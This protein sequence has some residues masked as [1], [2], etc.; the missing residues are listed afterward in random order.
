MAQEH[1]VFEGGDDG[2][3]IMAPMLVDKLQVSYTPRPRCSDSQTLFSA[4]LTTS[5][6]RHLI[7]RYK[8]AL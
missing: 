6:R 5:G 8:E 2:F 3:E 4:Q 1:D 7:G